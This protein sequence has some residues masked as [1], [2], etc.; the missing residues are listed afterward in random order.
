[1]EAPYFLGAARLIP[2]RAGNI[3]HRGV[4]PN[5]AAAH[6]RSRGEHAFA[7]GV[8]IYNVGSSPLARGTCVCGYGLCRV[9]RL[10]PA[11]A[12]NIALRQPRYPRV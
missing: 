4:H 1:M 8:A 6:P 3:L 12:G 7:L 2:A 11:R 5:L 9:V 10:I